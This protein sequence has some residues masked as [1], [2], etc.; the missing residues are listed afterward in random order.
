LSLPC[1]RRGLAATKPE[2]LT[3]LGRIFA[4]EIARVT[5]RLAN[6]ADAETGAVSF[7]QRFGGSLNWHV[8]VHTLAVDGVFEKH[9]A[10]LRVH[11]APPPEK[12]DVV[13]VIQRV[14]ER[15]LRW[16]RK[17]T[18]R[19]ER[20][21]EERGNE[22]TSPRARSRRALPRDG[23]LLGPRW[24]GRTRGRTARVS[25][26][27]RGDVDPSGISWESSSL[28]ARA[29]GNAPSSFLVARCRPGER[30]LLLGTDRRPGLQI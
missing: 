8:H 30:F 9:G 4:E 11:E 27:P 18:C 29:P 20:S 1:E 14:H 2:V 22:P 24:R 26:P 10:G 3:V 6:V 13:E 7:P 12:A 5:K 16:L 28:H 25:Y 19:G 15:A 21:A 17:H 23:P